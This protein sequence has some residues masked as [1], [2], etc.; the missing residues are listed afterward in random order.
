MTGDLIVEHDTEYH[1]STHVAFAQ[2]LAHLTPR[3]APGQSVTDFRLEIDPPPSNLHTSLD[4]FGNLRSYF[5][6]TVAHEALRVRTHSRVGLESRFEDLDASLSPAWE[7]VRDAL[8]YVAA[9]PF[10]PASEF[11]FSS[12]FV[13][14]DP[15]LREYALASFAAGRPLLWGRSISCTVSTGT[16]GTTPPA[17][18][19]RPP[20][21]MRSRPAPGSVRISRT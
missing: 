5:A 3:S 18:M 11:S 12:A 20:Y 8:Q 21:W 6:L 2:H 9:A 10:A 14:R 15:A 19:L 4:Y 16:F 17:P 13:P 7:Q 1:Y